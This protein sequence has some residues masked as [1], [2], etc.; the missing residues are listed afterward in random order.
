MQDGEK[1]PTVSALDRHTELAIYQK[2][3]DDIKAG[4]ADAI[5]EDAALL[6]V[7]A[8]RNGHDR[9]AYVARNIGNS[10]GNGSYAADGSLRALAGAAPETAGAIFTPAQLDDETMADPNALGQAYL[11]LEYAVESGKDPSVILER[12][13]TVKELA[14]ESGNDKLAGAADKIIKSI[15]DGSFDPVASE[16]DLMW[17]GA[18]NADLGFGS[19]APDDADKAPM[20][21]ELKAYNALLAEMQGSADITQVRSWAFELENRARANGDERLAWLARDIA[22]STFIGTYDEKAETFRL[23]LLG[24]APGTKAAQSGAVTA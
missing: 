17:N 4:N 16:L 1:S 21:D 9:L 15:E 7:V 3:V 18:T 10:I 23:A 24:M 13:K 11:D 20:S 19:P 6:A 2:L 12:A 8:A 14:E 22:H 5:V